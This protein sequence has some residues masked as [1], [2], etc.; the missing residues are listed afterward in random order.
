[1]LETVL[2]GESSH[3]TRGDKFDIKNDQSNWKMSPS[4]E[5]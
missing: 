5:P 4:K 2:T 1:M 3:W